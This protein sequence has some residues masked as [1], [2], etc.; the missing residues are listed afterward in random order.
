[1][2]D[3]IMHMSK[4]PYPPNFAY[5][6]RHR[7]GRI[8]G[9]GITRRVSL[10]SLGADVFRLQAGTA[11]SGP[12]L[13]GLDGRAFRKEPSFTKA[14]IT[15]RARLRWT[16]GD[17]RIMLESVPDQGIGF[18]GEAFMLNFL[19]PPEVRYFGLG[20]KNGSFERSGRRT[21]FWNTDIFGDF[22]PLPCKLNEVDPLY[23]SIPYLIVASEGRYLGILLDNPCDTFA[24]TTGTTGVAA[25]F[26]APGSGGRP[27]FSMGG[28]HGLCAAYLIFGPS[29][30]ELTRKLM[31]LVGRSPLPPLWAL[32][33]HQC[34]WGYKDEKDLLGL[35]GMFR[36][37]R[38]PV[39][40]L[41]LDIDYMRGF[42]VFTTDPG[43]FRSFARTV[44]GLRGRGIRVVPIMDPGVKREKG[45]PVYDDGVRSGVFCRNA[46]GTEFVGTVWP[47][48][49]VFPDFSMRSGREWWARHMAAFA[50]KGVEGVWLD[51]NDVSTG[52]VDPEGMLFG[53][54]RHPHHRF[55][56]QYGLGMAKASFE[57]FRRQRPDVRP[58]LLARSAS[59]GSG[60]YTA[61][62]MGDNSSNYQWLKGTIPMSLNLSL[63]GIPFNGGDV[64]GFSGDT[65]PLLFRRWIKAAFLMP[66]FRNHSAL[67]SR[68]QEPWALGR[69]TLDVARKY[70][71]L[72]YRFMPHLYN[73][74][75]EQE[76][77]GDPV[78]R[79][80]LYEFASGAGTDLS[81][82]DDEFLVGP[83]LL[84][85]P[86]VEDS[87]VRKALIPPGLWFDFSGGRWMK[88]GRRVILREKSAST[89][90]WGREGHALFL[91]T[92]ACERA[93]TDLKDVELHL[94]LP[95]GSRKAVLAEYYADDG[96]SYAYRRGERSGVRI[97]AEACGNGLRLE[98]ST[99]AGQS[100]AIRLRPV[101]Y[102]RFSR[103]I[104]VRDGKE[105]E[106]ELAPRRETLSGRA[107][108]LLQ[109]SVR[110]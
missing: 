32:G 34:R 50:A 25:P 18:C 63:S 75:R 81:K 92:D 101:L 72:R 1:M 11:P 56:N 100:G 93:E 24:F 89:P 91:R 76:E 37:H 28:E 40:G 26:G 104:V 10:E 17:G 84:H 21:R 69:E 57:G 83:S 9:K 87:P 36:R 60:R 41:W 42:R 15:D 31:L 88:G 22:H 90:L 19:A 86:H 66:F 51:M 7:R 33:Y 43:N 47:G 74:F 46:A 29:L 16:D 38:I 110:V 61:V 54:G 95:R 53:K 82:V 20:E 107:F 96:V 48:D 58:F 78:M 73:L 6:V 44:K 97:L 23:V 3:S 4:F 105:K 52:C 102:D 98:I 14:E 68:Q 27:V 13:S 49:T 62:W 103:L 5:A 79:P 45:Y 64:G 39:D 2:D 65:D 99:M 85:C 109:T 35:E 30:K 67:D 12:D 70:I 71:R 77:N 108:S 59:C 94:L 8:S 80:L 55:R 106:A